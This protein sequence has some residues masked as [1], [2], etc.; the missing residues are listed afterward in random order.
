M[1]G[2]PVFR[3]YHLDSIPGAT[4]EERTVRAFAGAF[5]A[6]D[7]E[8]GI[9]LD[10]PERGMILVGNPEHTSLNRTVFNAGRRSRAAGAAICGD[11]QDARLLLARCFAIA[12]RHG[13]MFF[14]DVE[15]V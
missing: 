2:F 11:G 3:W 13:P 15:H 1:H 10:T 5:L 12:Y 7:A 8:V 4:I 6:P 14:Y 9:D